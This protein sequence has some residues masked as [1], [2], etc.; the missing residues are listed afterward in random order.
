MNFDIDKF[1]VRLSHISQI[2]LL[3]AAIFTIWYTV[4]PLYG[5]AILEEQ[6][7]QKTLELNQINEKL[8]AQYSLIKSNTIKD[9]NFKFLTQCYSLS[10]TE[11]LKTSNYLNALKYDPIPCLNEQIKELLDR[12]LLNESDQIKIQLLSSSLNLPKIINRS[13]ISYNEIE[14]ISIDQIDQLPELKGVPK[15]VFSWEY[16]LHKTIPNP[17]IKKIEFNLRRDQAKHSLYLNHTNKVS[18]HISNELYKFIKITPN[19]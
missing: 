10:R 16:E 8:N 1:L 4:I 5:K 17:E 14:N 6:I 9:I 18:S 3:L 13:V 12:S 7:S 19:P 2:G 11:E 15:K